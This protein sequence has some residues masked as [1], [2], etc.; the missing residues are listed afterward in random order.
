MDFTNR[1][2]EI[3][4]V[5]H[6]NERFGQMGIRKEYLKPDNNRNLALA[7]HYGV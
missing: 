2:L 5:T 6:Y 7:N 4:V 1:Q 3:E